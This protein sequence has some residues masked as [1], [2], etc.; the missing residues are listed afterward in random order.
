MLSLSDL[1]TRLTAVLSTI[2]REARLKRPLLR[3]PAERGFQNPL[4]GRLEVDTHAE[5]GLIESV[6]KQ[7]FLKILFSL[8]ILRKSLINN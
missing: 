1:Q 7:L 6:S 4:Q 8:W 3:L 5:G 2:M